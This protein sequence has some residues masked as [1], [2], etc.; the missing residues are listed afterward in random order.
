MI[1]VR[2]T[3]GEGLKVL[4]EKVRRSNALTMEVLQS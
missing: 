4:P 3:S 1:L 2:S